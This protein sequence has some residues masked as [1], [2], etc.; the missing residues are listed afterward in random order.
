MASVEEQRV[1][2]DLE[3]RV[4][5]LEGLAGIRKPLPTAEEKAAAEQ[6]A[7]DA[8]D[9]AEYQRLQAKFASTSGSGYSSGR[10]P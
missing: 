4:Q 3:A 10:K 1:L 8:A 7:K 9:Q 5:T 2:D 6:A